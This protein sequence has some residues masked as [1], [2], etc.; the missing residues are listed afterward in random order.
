MRCVAMICAPR[1]GLRDSNSITSHGAKR[2][3]CSPKGGFI[4]Q[5]VDWL[6]L[7]YIYTECRR[8]FGEDAVRVGRRCPR[9]RRGRR[10]RHIR[11]TLFVCRLAVVLIWITRIC[12]SVSLTA[13][14][15]NVSLATSRLRPELQMD[16]FVAIKVLP[17]KSTPVETDRTNQHNTNQSLSQNGSAH[18]P[19]GTDCYGAADIHWLTFAFA[20]SSALLLPSNGR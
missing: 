5:F 8:C 19:H 16:P 18:G 4:Y 13:R 20:R 11:S 10:R 3:L 14:T 7:L 17:Q 9:R 15:E 2:M 6:P 1:K 12:L